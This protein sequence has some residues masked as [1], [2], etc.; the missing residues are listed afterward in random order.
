MA[1][2][3]DALKYGCTHSTI[4]TNRFRLTPQGSDGA[5]PNGSFRVRL[6]AKSLVRLSSLSASFITQITGLT[7]SAGTAWNN[8]LMP[9]SFKLF[10]SIKFIV[11]GQVCSGQLCN[12]YDQLYHALL[13]SSADNQYITSRYNEGYKELITHADDVN[14]P[15]FAPLATP[16]NGT[17]SISQYQILSDF[18]GLPRCNGGGGVIDTS[19]YNDVEIQFD[20]ND[21]SCLSTFAGATGSVAGTSFN[22]AQFRVEVDCIVS[23]SPMY[24][25]MMSL[26]L[27]DPSPIRFPYQN[28]VSTISTNTGSNRLQ[29]NTQS[30]DM[31]L[32]APLRNGWNV[33]AG[34]VAD[35]NQPLRYKWDTGLGGAS[36]SQADQQQYITNEANLRLQLLV[37]SDTYPKTQI[38]HALAVPDLTINTLFHGS[39]NSK[40][41]FSSGVYNNSQVFNRSYGL[42]DNFVWINNFSLESE[43][44]ASKKLTGIDTSSQNIDIIVQ[45]ANC[46]TNLFMTALITSQLVYSPDTASVSV[47]M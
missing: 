6:P 19:L 20:L 18:L 14:Y 12:N 1:D 47:V 4:R 33:L 23:V 36:G 21:T 40:N 39:L 15:A 27:Q 13:V 22:L 34:G 11:G 3:P 43:G 2:L 35:R 10:K 25:E 29:V 8:A 42:S 7:Y 38:D 45:S 44:W 26:R 31:F 17:T 46:G 28:F 16:A 24:V 32:V 37:G 30:L 41:L 9:S 5:D